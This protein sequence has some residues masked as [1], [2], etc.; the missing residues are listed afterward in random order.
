MPDK[1][2]AEIF[3]WENHHPTAVYAVAILT[4]K[5]EGF[6]IELEYGY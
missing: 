6:Q 5:L 2:S 1:W 4:A 3:A